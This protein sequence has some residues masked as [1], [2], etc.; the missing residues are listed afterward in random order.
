MQR[1]AVLALAF[2]L[3]HVPLAHALD[4]KPLQGS[5]AIGSATLID[6]PPDETKDRLLL[7]LDGR[8]AKDTY[9]AME[10]RARRSQCDP[11]LQTKTAGSL[12]CSMSKA[13]EYTCSIGVMLGSGRPV[14]AS[15]C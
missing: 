4:V 2:F 1:G 3:G 14:G 11:D 9:D 5:Y 10:A 13:G 7:Y 15:T 8:V 12:E 6:P